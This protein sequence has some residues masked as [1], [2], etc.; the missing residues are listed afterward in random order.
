[1]FIKQTEMAEILEIRL[2]RLKQIENGHKSPTIKEL[3]KIAKWAGISI[4]DILDKELL[5]DEVRD[6]SNRRLGKN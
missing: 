5:A 2:Y 3:Q 6:Y 4:L 1:M